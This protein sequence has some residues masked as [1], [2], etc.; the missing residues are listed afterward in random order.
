MNRNTTWNSTSSQYHFPQ[1]PARIQLSLWPA[2]LSSNGQGTVEW[3]GGL[4]DWN[5]QDIK[6]NGYYYA[7]V[8][9]VNVE[10]YNP[11]SGANVSGSNSYVYTSPA[12]T[13][14]TVATTNDNTVLKSLLGTGTN[15]S[16]GASSASGT[17]SASS[18]ATNV[19]QVPGLSGGG[20]GLNPGSSGSDSSGGGSDGG[21]GTQSS[22]AAGSSSTGIGGFSQGNSGS[23]PKSAA[24]PQGE[25]V[26]QGSMFAVLVAVVGLMVL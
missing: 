19:A 13:N 1:T 4:I 26:L 2:G 25:K 23:T 16:A 24:V 18:T 3:A 12:G 8:N 20:A 22:S 5:S 11:P 17:A 7:M 10:C 9:D 21:S 14:D 6:T 15:M